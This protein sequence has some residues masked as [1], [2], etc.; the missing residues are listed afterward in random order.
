MAP[1]INLRRGGWCGGG[2]DG[3]ERGESLRG[4]GWIRPHTRGD[5]WGARER[6]SSGRAASR[7]RRGGLFGLPVALVEYAVAYGNA[8]LIDGDEGG[9]GSGW[10]SAGGEDD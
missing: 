5:A 10:D 9:G 8:A 7:N 2:A 1:I 3:V 4:P 6:H